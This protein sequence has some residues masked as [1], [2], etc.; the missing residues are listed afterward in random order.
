M[1]LATSRERT[2][3]KV[4]SFRSTSMMNIKTQRSPLVLARKTE[5]LLLYWMT[6]V[7]WTQAWR[8]PIWR[9]EPKVT[10]SEGRAAC[11]DDG[12]ESTGEAEEGALNTGSGTPSKTASSWVT[13]RRL[14]AFQPQMR[15]W[16]V[17]ERTLGLVTCPISIFPTVPSA[18]TTGL[19]R[20]KEKRSALMELLHTS[21]WKLPAGKKEWE[22]GR[23]QMSVE[24]LMSPWQWWDPRLA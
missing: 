4:M 2:G 13:I 21:V 5:K 16:V 6:T 11:G 20:D 8:I 17:L 23:L 10:V 14:G 18:L 7:S 12:T 24:L 15:L 22:S 9:G 1:H 19:E 3:M